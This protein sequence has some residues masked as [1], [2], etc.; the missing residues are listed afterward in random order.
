[1][2][3]LQSGHDHVHKQT[4]G[5]TD[6]HTTYNV[7]SLIETDTLTPKITFIKISY[8]NYIGKKAD[9]R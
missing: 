2:S 4:N 5:Q 6:R 8:Q 7:A 9:F 3:V 1:M